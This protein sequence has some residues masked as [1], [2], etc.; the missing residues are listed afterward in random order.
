[1]GLI[2]R[3]SYNYFDV[4]CKEDFKYIVKGNIGTLFAFNDI[5]SIDYCQLDIQKFLDNIKDEGWS[6]I[7]TK[8]LTKSS[9]LVV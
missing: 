2:L 1:M 7:K 9:L 3:R 5:I 6:H 4:Y 8:E